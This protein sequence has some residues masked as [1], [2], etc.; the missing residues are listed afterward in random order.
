MTG[1]KKRVTIWDRD[2]SKATMVGAAAKD[3]GTQQK[4]DD[5]RGKRTQWASLPS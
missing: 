3:Q 2:M 5:E 1:G 4:E